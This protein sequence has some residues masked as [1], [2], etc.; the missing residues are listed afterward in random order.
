MSIRRLLP[1]LW[2]FRRTYRRAR[3]RVPA[4]LRL[5]AVIEQFLATAGLPRSGWWSSL[6]SPRD[7][8]VTRAHVRAFYRMAALHCFLGRQYA[9][10]MGI[11]PTP[12]QWEALA[13]I[14][15]LAKIEDYTVD[16]LPE[17]SANEHDRIYGDPHGYV[18]TNLVAA[19]F[20][21]VY[22]RLLALMPREQYPGY[23][24]VLDEIFKAQRE[25]RR[26]QR[27]ETP[28]AEL[29][30]ITLQKG[31]YGIMAGLHVLNP[32]LQP[33]DP[34]YEALVSIG[35]W[36][37]II[38]DVLDE[39]EDRR[40]GIRTLVTVMP[41]GDLE[42]ELVALRDR[43]LALVGKLRR[44]PARRR[45]EC[46]FRMFAPS[47]PAIVRLRQL[48]AGEDVLEAWSRRRYVRAGRLAIGFV[49]DCLQELGEFQ[50][51]RYLYESDR[52]E[53]VERAHF[54]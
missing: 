50:P 13:A 11:E 25:S 51:Q 40:Q 30:R 22:L 49:Q 33:G 28:V 8:A 29:R 46:L 3:R 37:Q 26:Q 10:L 52:S 47:V 44:Y 14:G 39:H 21:H 54:V 34:E 43:T 23:H 2:L 15:A 18:P 19:L 12:R 4:E 6:Y 17:F 41:P 7:R 1:F 32:H 36:G 45:A 42:R 31:G 5:E 38:E 9:D 24:D 48:A 27:R 53:A 20:R 16:C 35:R